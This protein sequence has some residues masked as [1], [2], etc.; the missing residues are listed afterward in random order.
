MKCTFRKGLVS[1]EFIFMCGPCEILREVK[2]GSRGKE[3]KEVH[4][5]SPFCVQ[6]CGS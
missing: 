5:L 1:E 3:E 4:L 2:G 6:H